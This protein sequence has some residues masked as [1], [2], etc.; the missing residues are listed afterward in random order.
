MLPTR[1]IRVCSAKVYAAGQNTYV[2][3]VSVGSKSYV[4]GGQ[5]TGAIAGSTSTGNTNFINCANAAEV[6]GE[7]SVGTVG[8]IV[9][10]TNESKIIGCSNSGAISAVTSVG[11][12]YGV[13]YAHLSN[14]SNI[15]T[16]TA[17]AGN[18]GGVAGGTY[19]KL[20]SC[21]NAGSVSGDANS[22][23]V[24]T[25]GGAQCYNCLYDGEVSK[26]ATVGFGA[27][28]DAPGKVESVT[29]D[30]LKSWGAAYQ[31]SRV[32]TTLNDSGTL[33]Y[34]SVTD[35]ANMTTW[36]QATGD[37]GAGT[38]ENSGYPVLVALDGTDASGNAAASLQKA[39]DWSQ[40]GNW[41]DVFVTVDE[42]ADQRVPG[43]T[44]GEPLGYKPNLATN[45]G[46]T[47]DLAIQLTNP[48]AFAWYAYKLNTTPSETISGST[49]YANAN[50][51]LTANIDLTGV[52]Y[53]G[54]LDTTTGITQRRSTKT[55]SN[56][57]LWAAPP[58]PSPA[59]SQ[60]PVRVQQEPP[61]A[62]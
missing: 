54:S 3:N 46:T 19:G 32:A 61:S 33:D 11:G 42:K 49:T 31:L 37:A 10:W 58:T 21:Y 4:C 52:S 26:P 53:G 5:G 60:V 62:T 27:N 43:A 23:A 56:G 41:V 12:V 50:V 55:P 20:V 7:S 40:V 28:S 35:L 16:V 59:R 24:V 6:K 30:V 38:L 14:C 45:N 8:G 29:T 34:A 1:I 25:R 39:A 17:S 15:G 57:C 22:G 47:E 18:A 44:A 13:G 51:K 9:G 36:R 48:E 2:Q